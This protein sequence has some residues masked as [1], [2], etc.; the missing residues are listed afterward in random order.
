MLEPTCDVGLIKSIIKDKDIW[1]YVSEDQAIETY[2]P[3]IREGIVYLL[4]SDEK[5]MGLFVYEKKGQ[6]LAE[7]HSCVLK[8][9]RGVRA[10]EMAKA[11]LAWIFRNTDMQKV[12][13]NVPIYNTSALL[14]ALRA[15]MVMEGTNRKSF[16]KNGRIHDQYLLGITREE[17]L[18][19]Q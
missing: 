5:P 12:I 19:Q 10:L 16:C 11:S 2:E 8:P 6:I 14:L 17:C 3:Q 15:G 13:T 18:S 9:F 1:D 7:V 4:A